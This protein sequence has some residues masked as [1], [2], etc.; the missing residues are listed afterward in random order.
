MTSILRSSLASRSLPAAAGFIPAYFTNSAGYSQPFPWRFNKR[1]QAIDLEY[2]DGFTSSTSLSDDEMFFRGQ[3]FGG[4]RLVQ[5]LGPKFIEWCEDPAGAIVADAGTV[6]LHE[7]PIV[8]SAN[9]VAPNQNPNSA[10][11][12]EQS[13]EFGF[14]SAAGTAEGQYCKTLVF[15]KPMVITYLRG[16]TRYY[17]WFNQ[18]FEG[19]S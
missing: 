4:L 9:M 8:V 7:K 19:N 2:V 13:Y 1:T 3:N 17:R 5:S 16:G 18:N 11:S 15:M 6:A 12:Q 10:E 14:E